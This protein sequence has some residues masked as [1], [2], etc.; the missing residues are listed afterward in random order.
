M[1]PILAPWFDDENCNPDYLTRVMDQLPKRGTTREWQHT[2]DHWR[3]RDEFPAID[4]DDDVF[5][6]RWNERASEAVD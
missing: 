3:E 4:L 2:Q 1:L 6:Y 5:V